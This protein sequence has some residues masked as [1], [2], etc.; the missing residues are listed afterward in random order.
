MA[1][2]NKIGLDYYNTDTDRYQDRKI[3]K[4]KHKH[5]P[6]G[7]AV[8]D[9]ILCQIYREKGCFIKCDDDF[10]FDVC[11]YY[12]VDENEVKL[13]INTCCAA[14]LFSTK[15]F[16]KFGILT[17]KSI[18]LRFEEITTSAKRKNRFIPS[19]IDLTAEEKELNTELT[20]ENT[21]ESTQRKE[22]ESKVKESKVKEMRFVTENFKS[23]FER[24]LKYRSEIKKPFKSE[25]AIQQCYENLLKLSGNDPIKANE[26]INQSISHEWQGLFELKEKSSA[27]KEKVNVNDGNIDAQKQKYGSIGAISGNSS[28]A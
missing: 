12:S 15:I 21:E 9:Y 19:E 23:V 28:Q 13:I 6:A 14:E 5:G 7:V 1:R 16:E 26:I 4:L 27:K 22:K 2:P 10:L 11:D 3:K 25:M 18:Q 17:S 20:K 8:Y 24:W